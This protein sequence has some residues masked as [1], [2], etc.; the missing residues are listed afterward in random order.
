MKTPI[1]VLA[2]LLA[3]GL[4]AGG[5]ALVRAGLCGPT[6]VR[7]ALLLLLGAVVLFA[8]GCVVNLPRWDFGRLLGVY[9]A[10]FFLMAQFIAWIG[11][12]QKP[13]LPLW[14]GGGFIVVGGLIITFWKP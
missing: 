12:S 4:E 5:D 3:A 11:F 8:Y 1:A 13:S 7:R 10:A 14:I 6:P 2:L 9:V